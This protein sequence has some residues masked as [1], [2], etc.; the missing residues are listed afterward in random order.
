MQRALVMCKNVTCTTAAGERKYCVNYQGNSSKRWDGKKIIVDSETLES[1]Y[2][3]KE[4][5][6]GKD[7]LNLRLVLQSL[8]LCVGR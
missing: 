6:L 3:V 5:V 4:L 7:S 8:T 2:D 1:L